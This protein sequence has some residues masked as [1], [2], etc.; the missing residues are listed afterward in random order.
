[1]SQNRNQI[2][3]ASFTSA[4]NGK[5]ILLSLYKIVG[6]IPADLAGTKVPGANSVVTIEIGP[7]NDVISFAVTEGTEDVFDLMCQMSRL[8][9]SSGVSD[10]AQDADLGI[11]DLDLDLDDYD[12]AQLEADV[13]DLEEALGEEQDDDRF[14]VTPLAW[15]YRNRLSD[16]DDFLKG[17]GGHAN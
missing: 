2:K 16:Y 17:Q 3:V 5:P 6:C 4:E 14:D 7:E 8:V 11:N 12:L 1:M 13:S 9:T 15:K 10:D